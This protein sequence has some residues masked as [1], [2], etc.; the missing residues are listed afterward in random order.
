MPT[1][2]VLIRILLET[3]AYLHDRKAC[4]RDVKPANILFDLNAADKVEG[5]KLI[6]YEICKVSRTEVIEMWTKTGTLFYKA[7][8]MFKS[9]YN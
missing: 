1:A 2:K 9:S 5:F 8:E 7:P 4:H 3:I 6:D